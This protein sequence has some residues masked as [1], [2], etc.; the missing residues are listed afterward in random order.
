MRSARRLLTWCWPWIKGGT[1]RAE[2][3]ISATFFHIASS[4][5][6]GMRP[7]VLITLPSTPVALDRPREIVP[8]RTPWP[9]DDAA[10]VPA[11]ASVRENQPAAV[12]G[13]THAA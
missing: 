10:A 5:K 1:S 9:A 11:S 13:N 6:A 4:W 8:E 2:R 3:Y 7:S 12:D